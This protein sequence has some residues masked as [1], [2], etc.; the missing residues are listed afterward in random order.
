MISMLQEKLEVAEKLRSYTKKI[1]LLSPKTD[2]IE[3]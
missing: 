1:L 2:F 3:I